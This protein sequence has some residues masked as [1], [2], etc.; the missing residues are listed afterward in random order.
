MLHVLDW[1]APQVQLPKRRRIQKLWHWWLSYGKSYAD[2][3]PE[4]RVIPGMSAFIRTKKRMFQVIVPPLYRLSYIAHSLFWQEC[5]DATSSDAT[6]SDATSSDSVSSDSDDL[7]EVHYLQPA[8]MARRISAALEKSPWQPGC[9]LNMYLDMYKTSVEAWRQFALVCRLPWGGIRFVP[10]GPPPREGYYSLPSLRG[11]CFLD[12][13][14][15]RAYSASLSGK[16][17]RHLP[18]IT[19]VELP[20]E[21]YFLAEEIMC[22][23]AGRKI[24][25]L[26]GSIGGQK[27]IAR[28]SEV[29]GLADPKLWFFVQA[30]EVHAGTFSP[31]D[32]V[33]F[34]RLVADPP[35]NLLLHTSYFSE[36][37]EFNA[38]IQIADIIF[39]VYRDFRNSSNMLGKAAYFEKP[40]LVSDEY[41]MG[42]MV[43]RYGIGL[44]VPQD[45]VQAMLW[46]LERLAKDLVPTQNF[47]AYRAAFSEQTAG[48]SLERFI[49][50][51]L[52]H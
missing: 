49:Q 9:L 24:V 44:A 26:G 25:F 41:L 36:E 21:L 46:A 47:A 7:S 16:Y 48:D 2:Q 39:A 1:D 10:S 34:E 20:E 17:F 4:S 12:E 15:C 18:D 6:S 14:T 33:A 37:R 30:G 38:I 22:R 23:A 50:H 45:D 42:E 52:T 5:S 8:D 11:M 29:I 19:N 3:Y 35:E 27:N 32:I 51:L 43:R 40:I 28:W 31:E 13:A